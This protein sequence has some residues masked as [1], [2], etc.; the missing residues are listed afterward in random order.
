MNFEKLGRILQLDSIGSGVCSVT[1]FCDEVY[2]LHD[3][4]KILNYLKLIFSDD[5]VRC[6][7]P[8]GVDNQ[9]GSLSYL[10]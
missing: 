10:V 7:L 3:G 1:E 6:E 4:R 2:L 8:L 9:V 5:F